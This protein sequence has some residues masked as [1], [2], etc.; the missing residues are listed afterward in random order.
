MDEEKL[1]SLIVDKMSDRIGDV[2]IKTSLMMGV[3]SFG[4]FLYGKYLY[5]ERGLKHE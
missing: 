5:L 3:V 2:L 4:I 1:S